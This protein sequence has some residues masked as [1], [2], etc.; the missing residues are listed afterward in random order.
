[1]DL[2]III[3]PLALGL[4]LG[5]ASLLALTDI[6]P[7]APA[8]A[9]A[10]L[11]FS[12]ILDAT[13]T[14]LPEPR[15]FQARD[16]A[17]LDFR[18]YGGED[19]SNRIIILIHGSGWHGGQ[20]HAMA[21]ALAQSGHITV[22][23]PDLRGHG[24]H[25]ERRGDIN[26]IGQLEDDLADLI[27]VLAIV[28]PDAEIVVGGHSSGGGLVVRFAGGLHGALADR[29]VLLA[30]FLGYDAPTT[31]KN[32]GGWAHP[33]IRRII[34]LTLLNRLGITALNH[35]P[36]ISFA[37]P[38]NVLG[39]R[40]GASAT[41]TYSFRLNTSYAPRRNLAADLGALQQPFLLLAGAADEAFFA[42]EYAPLISRHTASGTY[43]VLPELGHLEIAQSARAT[44][45]LAHWLDAPALVAAGRLPR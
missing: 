29:Y 20:F 7:D 17:N 6:P 19:R 28:H 23:V 38:R 11:D 21:S 43:R 31:R 37:F 13:E 24:S 4:Y 8:P 41:P 3:P 15:Q 26:Y 40:Q 5:V 33:A 2:L 14:A 27:G 44:A 36:V 45:I 1:M 16:G 32:S 35:L 42:Y 25:P 10:G 18:A 30:P 12:A 9:D 34:G 39:G 22:I